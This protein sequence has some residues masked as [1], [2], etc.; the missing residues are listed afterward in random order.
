[1]KVATIENGPVDAW[2]VLFSPDSK[3][4]VSG[5]HAGKVYTLFTII[6]III[7]VVTPELGSSILCWRIPL[8][9][10]AHVGPL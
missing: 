4:V 9:H 5:S 2:T 10:C 6:T 7:I 8:L 1:M 3:H